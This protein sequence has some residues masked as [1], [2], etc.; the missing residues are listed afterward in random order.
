MNQLPWV[1]SLA[2]A[3]LAT[4]AGVRYGRIL[5]HRGISFTGSI[6]LRD[7]PALPLALL[8]FAL[9]SALSSVVTAQAAWSWYLPVPVEY[10][11]LPGIWAAKIGFTAFA[12]AAMAAIAWR[13]RHKQRIPILLF[14]LCAV[15]IV[16]GLQRRASQ[17]GLDKLVDRERDGLILQSTGDTCAAATCANIA[18]HLGLP[19]TESEMVALLHTT[20]LGTSPAQIVYGM[21]HLGL[22]ARK[23]SIASRD[24]AELIP[25]AVLLVD[26]GDLPFAHAVAYV[27]RQGERYEIWDP[28]SGRQLRT[29]GEI[30]GHWRGAAIE[31][32]RP[33][34]GS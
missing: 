32:S 7:M 19:A 31:I 26:V 13:T 11:L 17:P 4:L 8:A 25:P 27:G 6:R 10:Y 12:L 24:P 34:E 18:R 14:A 5:H 22:E 33:Q 20:W 1:L 15:L 23:R 9:L 30:Q 2:T 16:E 29:L 28:S 3:C 21:R